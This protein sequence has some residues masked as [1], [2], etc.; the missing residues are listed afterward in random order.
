MAIGFGAMFVGVTTA[1]N[2]GVPSNKAG[3][4]AGL[5]STSQQL[6]MALGLAIL[7]AIATARTHQLLVAHAARPDALTSGYQRALLVC[8]VF[9]LSAAVIASRIPNAHAAAQPLV[10]PEAA[11]EP[12]LL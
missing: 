2:A 10:V 1:A 6:G 12:T 3:V 11:A 9:V 8:S 5:L 7:S 4:A